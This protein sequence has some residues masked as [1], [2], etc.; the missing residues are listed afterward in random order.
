MDGN[1]PPVHKNC[2]K[3]IVGELPTI[4]QSSDGKYTLKL[5]LVS[6]E[7]MPRWLSLADSHKV[8]T[9][10][11]P[12]RNPFKRAAG[13]GFKPRPRLQNPDRLSENSHPLCS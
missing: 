13:R 6:V 9:G 10:E 4:A 5:T 7:R 1:D 3:T 8:G 2:H 12:P 11:R